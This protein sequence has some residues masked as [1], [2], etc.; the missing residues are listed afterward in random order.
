MKPGYVILVEKSKSAKTIHHLEKT[1][2]FSSL[3]IDINIE[4]TRCCRKTRNGLNI[5]RKSVKIPSTSS[6]PDVPDWDGKTSWRTL[7]SWIVTKTVLS[8]RDAEGEVTEALLDVGI[9]LIEL[10][11]V[12][13]YLNTVRELCLPFSGPIRRIRPYLRH[14]TSLRWLRC[15]LGAC[16]L[17]SHTTA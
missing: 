1:I 2:D 5:C 8:L 3:S 15:A 16:F 17:Q 13:A 7:E 14:K 6:E 4:V 10:V 12:F 9:D 11:L